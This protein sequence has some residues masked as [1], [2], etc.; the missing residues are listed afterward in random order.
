MKTDF[1]FKNI[2]VPVSTQESIQDKCSKLEKVAVNSAWLECRIEGSLPDNQ[3]SVAIQ[4]IEPD[5]YLIGEGLAENV[6]A[7]TDMSVESLFQE[8]RRYKE[9]NLKLDRSKARKEKQQLKDIIE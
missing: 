4:Y 9:K 3:V 5:H 8:I 6:L 2:T 7:A 1:F